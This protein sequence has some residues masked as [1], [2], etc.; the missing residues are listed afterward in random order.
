MR[1]TGWFMLLKLFSVRQD[2][3][4]GLHCQRQMS[5]MPIHHPDLHVFNTPVL[6]S[7]VVS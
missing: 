6:V 2:V 4:P 7:Y 5:Y 3:N 1:S